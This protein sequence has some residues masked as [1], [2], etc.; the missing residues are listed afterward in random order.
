MIKIEGERYHKRDRQREKE[1]RKRRDQEKKAEALRIICLKEKDG[2]IEEVLRDIPCSLFIIIIQYYP[3]YF[4]TGMQVYSIRNKN[5]MF[6]VQC[7]VQLLTDKPK[8]Y[9]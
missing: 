6:I 2:K 9:V 5:W 8:I 3:F 7:F 4:V 1:R